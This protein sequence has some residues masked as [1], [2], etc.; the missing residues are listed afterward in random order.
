MPQIKTV[1]EYIVK[2]PAEMREKLEE[3]R[4]LILKTVPHAEE[5]ISYSMP[6]YGYKGRLVYFAHAQ[7][8]LGLYLM[9]PTIAEHRDELREY[10]TSTSTI[11]LPLYKPLPK[12]LI[13]KL[14]LV[15][16]KRNDAK[17]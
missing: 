2:A 6:Y 15:G 17:K 7:N 8:H 16:V 1:D 9:P 11:Q 12:A 10:K 5:K 14:I 3:L 4:E 13:K